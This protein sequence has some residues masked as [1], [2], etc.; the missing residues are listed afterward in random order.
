MDGTLSFKYSVPV[1]YNNGVYSNKTYLKDY[2]TEDP[3][4]EKY[5]YW[6]TEQYD[7]GFDDVLFEFDNIVGDM[8]KPVEKIFTFDGDKITG[9]LKVTIDG[10]IDDKIGADGKSIRDIRITIDEVDNTP[11]RG[12]Y[13]SLFDIHTEYSLKTNE[14]QTLQQWGCKSITV[15]NEGKYPCYTKAGTYSRNNDDVNITVTFN[16]KG[17]STIATYLGSLS[18]IEVGQ[19]GSLVHEDM[20]F[21]ISGYSFG[22]G[23]EISGTITVGVENSQYVVKSVDLKYNQEVWIL[24]GESDSEEKGNAYDSAYVSGSISPSKTQVSTNEEFDLVLKVDMLKVGAWSPLSWKYNNTSSN[25]V[26]IR[27]V[28]ID[29]SGAVNISSASASAGVSCTVSNDYQT[30]TANSSVGYSRNEKNNRTITFKPSVSL[31]VSSQ[32]TRFEKS[33][34]YYWSSP[35]NPKNDYPD[36]FKDNVTKNY[37]PIGLSE[38]NWLSVCGDKPHF[39]AANGLSHAPEDEEK[40]GFTIS[41]NNVILQQPGDYNIKVTPITTIMDWQLTKD[42]NKDNVMQNGDTAEGVEMPITVDKE[43]ISC[44][45][46]SDGSVSFDDTEKTIMFSGTCFKEFTDVN[47]ETKKETYDYEMSGYFS[48]SNFNIVSGGITA[49]I[50]ETKEEPLKFIKKKR[51]T[52]EIYVVYDNE[53]SQVKDAQLDNLINGESMFY[54]HTTSDGDDID[55]G[56]SIPDIKGE[57]NR[58]PSKVSFTNGL[59]NLETTTGMFEE[60]ALTSTQVK[61]ILS[62]LMGNKNGGTMIIG[63]HSRVEYDDDGLL[64]EIQEKYDGNFNW[65]NKKIILKTKDEN[66]AETGNSWEVTLK[67]RVKS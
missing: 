45:V 20:V 58:I 1:E 2:Y 38:T 31:S 8:V 17:K 19:D 39:K 60:C 24:I 57:Y 28:Y 47:D 4:K 26:R 66:G 7:Y 18:Y 12:V 56:G 23:E 53:N 61:G 35:S 10:C 22:A 29:Q 50:D 14:S 62:S 65:S 5:A 43:S 44:Y 15:K 16:E 40:G 46:S 59:T 25:D 11:L 9:G 3:D 51:Q 52:S 63:I 37:N 64:K 30:T 32:Y 49:K 42:N 6:S 13:V 36:N 48:L 33:K 67:V 34:T 55:A 27:G 21:N 41:L 54:N